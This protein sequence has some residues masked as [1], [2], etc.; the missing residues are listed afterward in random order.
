MTDVTGKTRYQFIDMDMPFPYMFEL[1]SIC[2]QKHRIHT[3][4]TYSMSLTTT[5][6]ELS[7]NL[8][9]H[10]KLIPTYYYY[11]FFNI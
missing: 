2:S 1:H 10:R 3:L 6:A 7:E 5:V 8:P 11:V 9:I 4:C